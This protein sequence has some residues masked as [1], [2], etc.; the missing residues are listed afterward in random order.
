MIDAPPVPP[1]PNPQFTAASLVDDLSDIYSRLRL[2]HAVSDVAQ[3]PADIT[4]RLHR[5][6][7]DVTDVG[8]A[9]R[10]LSKMEPSAWPR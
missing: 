6:Y 9:L 8:L 3:F 5:L 1:C 10:A 4:L 7:V 2:L